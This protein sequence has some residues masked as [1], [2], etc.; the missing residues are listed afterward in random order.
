MT[1][2]IQY[3]KASASSYHD[4]ENFVV[5]VMSI[6]IIFQYNFLFSAEYL[7]LKYWSGADI[8]TSISFFSILL[9]LIVLS[10]NI[11]L[12]S[13]PWK[14][15]GALM[16]YSVYGLVVGLIKNE[17]GISMFAEAIF[18]IEI[19]LYIFIFSSVSQDKIAK[20]IRI[21]MY[22]SAANAILS[23]IYF[24]IIRDQVAVAA[25]VGDQ[26]IVRIAD[27]LAPLLILLFIIQNV[28]NEHKK[29]ST[30]WI[31]PIVAL[32]LLGFFRSVWAAFILAY[33]L[34]NAF[35]ITSKSFMRI[36]S[37][38]FLLFI[39]ILGFEYI[40]SY[41]FGVSNVILGRIIAGVGTE[42]SLGRI[43]SAGDVLAQMLDEPSSVIFGAGFGKFVGFVNDFGYGAIYA[44]QPLAT[45]SNYYVVFIFEVGIFIAFLYAIYIVRSVRWIIKSYNSKVA[46]VLLLAL[47]YMMAQW[48]TFPTTIHYPIAMIVGLFFALASFALPSN[49]ERQNFRPRIVNRYRL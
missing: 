43:S 18:W 4:K 15:V 44:M 9:C 28:I 3:Q 11:K 19:V 37:M 20:L 29:I 2:I 42:D 49:P 38:A 48:L 10:F 24:W 13:V 17:P 25:V 45:L 12:Q 32:V 36:T 40:F 33:I 23:I 27:L 47:F 14:F 30:L 1:S 22:Y 41:F 16:F 5:F 31:I 39:F 46:K 34:S 21:I 8:R 6:S 35:F 7:W 26:R